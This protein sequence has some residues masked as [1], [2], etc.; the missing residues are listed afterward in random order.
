MLW[1]YGLA[2]QAEKLDWEPVGS[3][4]KGNVK[5]G[6]LL[7]FSIASYICTGLPMK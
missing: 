3:V 4:L 1:N 6:K 7:G 5:M 2:I